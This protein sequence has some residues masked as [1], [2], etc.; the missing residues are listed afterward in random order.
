MAGFTAA[1]WTET[2]KFRRSRVPLV[3]IATFM[4][5]PLVD[6]LFMLIIA[7]PGFAS[8]L[9]ILATK[10]Q[11]TIG[12]ADWPSYFKF[13]TQALA[14]GGMFLFGLLI[15]WIFGRE[16][17]DRTAKDLLALP[18]SRG[19]IVLA[20]FI[21]ITC[22]SVVL[23]LIVI[24]LSVGVGSALDLPGWSATLAQH[25]AGVLV[26]MGG[27]TMLLVWPFAI[28]ASAGRGYLPP[29]GLMLLAVVLA[30][31]TANIGWG[32]YFPWAVAGL[33]GVSGPEA[34]GV[35]SYVLVLLTGLAGVLGTLAWWQLADQT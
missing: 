22:W 23:G 28:A 31:L 5:I 25:T 3:S 34:V 13:L 6:G 12:A 1:L 9:G 8:R 18:T 24:V 30:E 15:T 10:A 20:K 21:V 27:L 11:L 19:A 7:N 33:V 14:A 29:F 17:S 4:I 2:L 26:L 32:P 16:Y 35:V